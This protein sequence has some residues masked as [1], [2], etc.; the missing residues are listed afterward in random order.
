MFAL[1]QKSL[2][3]ARQHQLLDTLLDRQPARSPH[4]RATR[5]HPPQRR[6]ILFESLEPRLLL[7]ADLLPGATAGTQQPPPP[8]VTL[9]L[10]TPTATTPPQI[11]WTAPLLTGDAPLYASSLVGDFD[12]DNFN[13]P[14]APVAPAGG[15]V[16]AG[17]VQGTLDFDG[18]SDTLGITLDGNQSFSLR[19]QPP[20]GVQARMEAFGTDGLSLGFVEAANAGDTLVLQM[21]SAAATGAY[22][23]LVESLAGAGSYTVEIFLNAA[24]EDPDSDDAST[25]QDLDPV[26]S[27]LLDSPGERASVIGNLAGMLPERI[28]AEENFNNTEAFQ[29]DLL[30]GVWELTTTSLDASIGQVTESGELGTASYLRMTDDQNPDTE[31][32]LVDNGD[33]GTFEATQYT[34]EST[35]TTA[36]WR[37]NLAGVTAALLEFDFGGYDA[38]GNYADLSGFGGYANFDGVSLSVGGDQWV[39]LESYGYTSG[40]NHASIN[41][42]QAAANAGLTLGT[43][44][45]IRFQMY[46]PGG[47]QIGSRDAYYRNFDNIRITTDQQEVL[48]TPAEVVSSG[49]EIANFYNPL[50]LLTDGNVP[51]LGSFFADGTNVYWYD[52]EASEVGVSPSELSPAA[53]ELSGLV[54]GLEF[55]SVQR[56]TGLLL[57]LD[58]NDY[59]SVDYSLDGLS[60][61]RLVDI[62]AWQGQVD[63]G[64]DTFRISSP[65]PDNVDAPSFSPVQA[66][67]LRLYATAGDGA[68]AIGEVQAFT[69]GSSD[70]ADYY[71]LTLVEGEIVSFTLA[72]ENPADDN[73]VLLQLFDADGN[74]LT[75]GLPGMG[76][77][78]VTIENFLAP[79]AGSYTVRVAGNTTGDYHLAAVKNAQFGPARTGLQDLTLTPVLL[80]GLSVGGSTIRVGVLG[81]GYLVDQLNDDTHFDFSASYVDYYQ[82]DSALEL[83]SFDVIVM[84]NYI[85]PYDLGGIAPTLRTWVE[86]GHGLVT[87]GWMNYYASLRY[88]DSVNA[89]LDAIIPINLN[90]YSNYQYGRPTVTVTDSTHPVTLGLTDFTANVDAYYVYGENGIDAD[91]VLLG[92]AFGA[93]AI[94]AGTPQAGRTVAL[95]P[96]YSDFESFSVGQPARLLEQAVAWAAKPANLYTVQAQAGAV[97]TITLDLLGSGLGEPVNDLAPV[98]EIFDA[99]GSMLLTSGTTLASVDV[100]EDALYTVR[101]TGVGTGDFLLRASG[102]LPSGATPVEVIASNLDGLSQ[103]QDFPNQIDLTFSEPVLYT[104]LAAEDLMVNGVAAIGYSILSPTQVRFNMAD[105][106]TGDGVYTLVLSEGSVTDIHGNASA[107]WVHTLTVDTQALTVVASSVAEGDILEPGAQT[108]SFVLS[109]ALDDTYLGSGDLW[110]R[111]VLTNQYISVS[112]FSYDSS[113]L[114]VSATTPSL[115]EGLYEVTLNSDFFAFKDLVGNLL[116]GNG[117]GTGGDP[118]RLRFA[119]DRAASGAPVLNAVMPLGGLVY[120]ADVTDRALHAVGDTDAFTFTLAAGQTL[121]LMANQTTGSA[122]MALELFDAATGGN[123]LGLVQAST[124]GQTVLLQTLAITGGTYRAEVRSLEGAARYTLSA[125]LNAALEAELAPGSSNDTQATAQDISNS[126]LVTG[127]DRAAV[128]GQNSSGQQDWY[129][130]HLDANQIASFVLT[131]ATS[132]GAS[133]LGLELY[134]AAGV[135][136]TAGGDTAANVDES[137]IDFRALEAGDYFLRVTGNSAGWYNLVATRDQS[138]SL[139]LRDALQDISATGEVLGGLGSGSG[140]GGNGL[141][142]VVAAPGNNTGLQ[143]IVAQLND[144]TFANNNAVFVSVSDVDTLQELSQFSAVLIGG[145]GHYSNQFSGFA[146]NLRAYVEGGGGL[147]VTGWGIY[148]AGGLFGQTDA[149]FNAIVPVNTASYSWFGYPTINPISGHP[150]TNGVTSFGGSEYTEY[151]SSSPQIKTGATVLATVGGTPVA[152]AMDVGKGRSVYLGPTYAGSTTYNTAT[153]RTGEAD[154]LLEQAAAWVAG[155]TEDRYR[156]TV[157][158]GDTLTLRTTTPLDGAG[159]PGNALDVGIELRDASGA[160]VA[161]VSGGA[162]DGRNVEFVHVALDSG[163]YTVRVFSDNASPQGAYVLSVSGATGTDS[164]APVVIQSN[165]MDG[166]RLTSVPTTLSFDLSHTVLTSSLSV[167][168]L[169]ID[170]G[171]TVTGVEMVDGDTVRFTLSVPDAEGTYQ[172]SLLAGALTGLQGGLSQAHAGSFTVDKTAPRIVSQAPEVQS[173]SP[174]NTW[175]VTFNEALNPATVQTGDFVLR[176][177]N[178]NSVFINTAVVSEDRLTVTL[179]FSNQFTQGNYQLTVGPN[180][181]DAAGNLMDQDSATEGNQTYLGTVQVASP[182]LNPI[183][184]SVTL[185]D[186]S[187]V[188]EGGAA[189]G[190]QV[191]V[192]WTVRNIGTDAARSSGWYDR[193]FISSDTNPSGDIQLSEHLVSNPSGL[194]A[195]GQYAM[196]A[197]VTLPL[198]D[199]MGAGQYY[200][201]VQTDN[202]G[203]QPENNENNNA[204]YSAAFATLVPPLPDLT[205]SNVVAPAVIEAAKVIT[206]SWTVN[207]QGGATASGSSGSWWDRVVLSSDQVF[208]NGDDVY[209]NDI[210]FFSTVA[211]GQSENRST[212]VTVP[213][214]RTGTWHVLVKADFY[215]NVYERDNEN[216]NAGATSAPV[217]VIIPTEDLTPVSLTAPAAAVFGN[218]IEVSWTVRNAGTGPTYGNWYDRLYLS[219]DAVLGSGD[220]ALN[221]VYASESPDVRPVGAGQEYTRSLQNVQLPLNVSLTDGNYFLLLRTDDGNQEPELSETNNV[222]ARAISLS[223]P[224]YPDLTVTNVEVPPSVQ[225]GQPFD[226]RFTLNNAGE[227]AATNFNN[228]IYLSSDGISLDRFVGSVF[229]D[230]SLAAGTSTTVD[231]TI[232]V[233]LYEPGTWRVIVLADSSGQ[234]YEHAS[235]GNNRGVSAT[236]VVATLPPLPDLVVSNI[237]APLQG[238]AGDTI[239][240]SWTIT[241]QGTADFSGT[242]VDRV[243]LIGGGGGTEQS[244]G[245]FSFEGSLAVGASVTRTQ[246]LTLSATQDGT[247]RFVVQTDSA[248]Q[249]NET[250]AGQ[251]NNTTQDNTDLSITFPPL[252]NLQV[253][254]I[255]PPDEPFSG[256]QTTIRWVVTNNGTGAT[257]AGSWRDQVILSLD[258]KWETLD[259]NIHLAT[260]DNPNYLPVGESYQNS[261]TISIPRGLNGSYHFLVRTDVFGNVFEDAFENDNT[262][263]TDAILVQLTPPPDLRVDT[264][265][266][267]NE[268]FSGT[269]ITISWTVSNHGEGPTAEP[270]WY[271]RVIMSEN[272]ILGDADDRRLGDVLHVGRLGKS[273]PDATDDTYSVSHTFNLPIGV[274]GNFHFFVLTDVA[275]HVYEHGSDGNN[276]A[277]DMKTDGTGPELTTILLTPPPDLEVY[278]VT[279]PANVEAGH[280]YN[281]TWRVVNFGSTPTPNSS[282]TDR[283]YLSTDGVLDA[284][285]IFLRDA[286]RSGALGVVEYDDDGEFASGFYDATVSFTLP[287]NISGN[288]QLIVQTDVS[289]QVFEGFVNPTGAD[290]EDNNQTASNTMAVAN[291]PADLVVENLVVPVTGEAGKQISL[292][293][294]VRNTGTGDSVAPN[295]LD[296]VRLSVDE[297]LFD[298]DD[299]FL[300]NVFH[301]GVLN[302]GGSYTHTE[303]V[304][305]P[306]SL[307]GGTYRLYVL[308]DINGRVTE[309]SETNNTAFA[310][311][312]VLRETPD[313]QV[314]NITHEAS[315]MVGLNLDVAWRVDNLG[316]NQTNAGNW[317]DEVFLS[318]DEVLDTDDTFLGLRYRNAALASGAGYNAAASFELPATLA[319]NN[320]FVIVRTDRNNN[321]TEGAAGETNNVEVSATTVPVVAFDPN[322][323]EGVLPVAL[324]RPDLRVTAV[325]APPNA[326]SGQMMSVTWTVTN[327]STD[328]TGNRRWS[329]DVYLSRD[330][331][332]DR[333]TDLYLGYADYANL[334]A[335]ASYTQVLNVQVPYGQSGPFYLFVAT[336]SGQRITEANEL[337]N[338]AQDLAFTEV[339]LAPPADLVVGTITIPANGIPGQAATIQFSVKNEGTNPAL[340]SWTDSVYLST[341]GTWDIDDALFGVVTHHG[342]VAGGTS[343]TSSLTGILPG[344]TPGS[345]QVIV[346]SDI[347]NFIP[348][349]NENNNIK[350]TLDSVAL[351]VEALAF[352][353]AGVATDTGTLGMGQAVYYKFVVAAGETVRLSFDGAGDGLNANELYVRQGSM[354][355]RGQYDFAAREGF[356]TDPSLT[357]P[358]TEAGTYYVLAY[359]Q[360]VSG[361][362]PYTIRAEIIPFSI[363]EVNANAVGNAGDV[364]LRIEGAKFGANTEFSLVAPDGSVVT[365]HAVYLDNSSEA[366]A[367][368]SLFGAAVGSYDVRAEQ[369]VIQ[370]DGSRLVQETTIRLDA[371]TV[372][373]GLE[374]AVYMTIAG[375]TDVMVNRTAI[376]TLNYT[377]EGGADSDVPLMVVESFSATP[378]GLTAS[379]LHTTPL[380]IL[381]ASFDGPMDTLRPGARY[382]VPIVFKTGADAGALDIRVGRIL[383]TD[384]R[385]ITDWSAI[386]AGARPTDAD[387]AEWRTFWDRV[388]PLIGLTWGEYVQVLDRMMMLVS[389]PGNPVRDVREIF[390]RMMQLNPAYIPYNS[391]SGEV[392]DS[393]TDAGLADVQM[394]AYLLRADGSLEYKASALSAADGSF[395]FTRLEP[396]QYSVVAIGQALDMDR[397][398]QLDLTVPSVTLGHAAPGDAGVIYIQPPAGTGSS[399]DSN[400]SLNR[401]ANGVTHMVW[402]REGM[403]WHAWFDAASGKWKD[404]QALSSEDGYGPVITSSD[405]LFDGTTAGTIVAWQQG[406][407]NDANI[408]YAVARAKTGGGFEWSAPRQLTDVDPA[409]DPADDVLDGA[410]QIIVGDT[411]TVMFTFIKRDTGINADGTGVQDDSDLYFEIWAFGEDEFTWPSPAAV[412]AAVEDTASD[413][414]LDTEGVSAAYGRQWKFGPWNVLGGA[415]ELV[416][417]LNGT[418]SENNCKVT[419][420][421]QGQ[422]QGS[423]KG[424][425]IRSTVSGNGAVTAEWGVNQAAKDWMFNSAKASIGANVQFDWRYGLSTLLSKIPH[426]AVTAA[427]LMYSLAVGL[428]S[429]LGLEFE[430]GITFG[431]GINISVMEWKLIQPFPEFVRPDGIFEADLSG[432]FGVYAQLDVGPTGDSVRVQGDITV[433]L[434]IEPVFKIKSVTGNITFSGNIGWVPFNSVFSVTLYNN[435]STD[436]ISSDAQT[437]DVYLPIFDADALIGTG[438]AY[439]DNHVLDD[440]SQDVTSDS[441]MT[442]AKDDGVI[443]GAWTHMAETRPDEAGWLG[444]I[445]WQVMVAEY[446]AGWGT[447]V[448]LP[449]SLGVN[450]EA[451]AAV[452]GNGRRMVIWTHAASPASATP[453]QAELETAMDANNLVYALYDE[454]TGTWGAMQT[455]ATTA[456]MDNGITTTRNAAGQLVVSWV[457]QAAGGIDRL[458]TATWNGSSWSTASEVAFGASI[459]DPA[460]ERLGNDLIVVWEADANPDP[461]ETEKSLYYSIYNGASWSAGAMFDPIAMATGMALSAGLPQATTADEDL[462]LMSGFPPFPVP[463]ECLKCKPEEIKRIR[464]SAP[465]CIDG[466]GTQVTFDEKTC[467]EK[468]IVYR[469][470]V[471]RPR[472][473]NDIIGPEG[474][475]EEGWIAS[476]S[477]LDYMIRF[478]NAADASAPAQKVIITQ[479]LDDDLDWRTFRIDDFGFG[480]QIINLDGRS[481]F[482]Q[483]RLDYTADPTRGYFLD[484]S[485]SVDVTT[486]IVTWTMTTIDPATGDL[487]QEASIGFLPVNDT[488]YDP[489]DHDVV[490]VQGTGRGEGYVTY[491]VRAKSASPTG[492][493]VDAEARIIFDTEAP[494][495]TPAIAHTLD[496]GVPTSQVISF[497]NSTTTDGE[498]LVQW[499]GED[500]AAGSGLRDFSVYVSIDGGDFE[501]WLPDTTLTEAIYLGSEGHTYRFFSTVRDWAGNEERESFVADATITVTG[502]TGNISGTK[503]EDYDGDGVRDAGE[504]GLAGWTIYLDADNDSQ[505]DD[506]EIRTVTGSDGG[507]SFLDLNP[508]A[509]TV[510]EVARDGWVQ[511][512]PGASGHTANVVSGETRGGVDFGNFALAQI[513]GLLFSDRNA[514]GALDD[515]EEGLAGWTLTLDKDGNGSVEATTTT[516]EYGY[517]RFTGVGPGSYTVMQVAQA[518]WLPTGPAS[519]K[520]VAQTTSGADIGGAD[521]A[522]VQ[523]ASISGT[524]FEDENGNGQRDLDERGL[525]GWTIFLDANANG[526]LDGSERFVVTGADGAY[527]FANLLPGNYVIAEVMQDGWVQTSPGARPT[528]ATAGV[529]LSL[530]GMDVVLSLPEDVV[531]EGDISVQATSANELAATLVGLDA[532]RADPRFAGFNGSGVTT[533]VIDTGIDLNHSWFGPDADNNGVADRIVYSYDFADGDANAGDLNGH[534][535]HI[536]S[537][538]GGQD[539]TYGGV[540]QGADLIALKVFKDN[541]SGLFSYLESALQWVVV[542]AGAYDVGV[543]NLSLGDG[544]NWDT[545]IGRYGLGDE[546]AALAGMNILVTAASGNNY[547]QYSGE[548]GVAYPAADPAVLAVGA[549]WSGSFGGPVNYAN[550]AIDYSTG[551]DVLAAFGQRDDALLDILAPGTRMVGANFNGGTRTMFGTSQASAYM[552]GIA[553]LAQDIALDH[554]GRKLGLAEFSSLLASTSVLVTDGDDENDNVANTGLQFARIDLLALA[555]GILALDG[556]GDTGGGGGTSTAGETRP[557]AAPGVHQFNLEAGENHTGTDFGN[558]LLGSISGTV[559]DD[560]N[561]NAG[562]DGAETGLGGWT[563]FLDGNA[564]G[565]RDIGEHATVTLADGS[566][567]FNGIGPG[568]YHVTLTGQDGWTATTPV[569]V[570]FPMASGLQADADFGVNALPTL[571]AIGGMQVHEGSVLA[572]SASAS[573]STGDSLAYSL[574]GDS[575]GATI[576]A[577]TGAFS[578][579]APDGNANAGFTVR[580]TDAAGGIAERSFTVTVANVAPSLTLGGAASVT[581]DQDFV[582]DLASSDPGQDTLSG[583]TIQWGDGSSSQ[584][585][586][587]AGSLAH[588]YAA[589]GDYTVLATASDEDGSYS[590]STTVTVLPGTLKVA[591]LTPTATGFQVRFNRGFAPDEI[592]LYDSSFYNRGA[593]DIALRDATGRSVAGSVVLDDDH[594]GLTFVRTGGLLANG[595]YTVTLDS[596]ADAFAT[597]QG[598]LLDG[599]R[600][601]IAGGHFSGSFSITGSGAVLRIGEFT[602]GAG[603][604]VD[605]PATGAGVPITISGATGAQQVSF[606]LAYDSALLQITGVTGGG[607]LPA[608]STVNADFSTPGA[609]HITLN[610]GSPLGANSLELVRLSA[611]VPGSAPY[612]AKQVLDLRDI[613]LDTGAPVRDDDGLHLAAYVGDTSGNAK[614]ST[615]DVQRIQR[616]VLRM[617]SGFGAYPLIDPVVV[618]DIN[619]NG[620]LSSLDAQ[621]VLSEVMGLDRAEIPAIPQGMTLTFSGP[622]PVV[623]AASVAAM[624]GETVVV[625]I[626]LDTAAGLESVEITLLY[627]ADSLELLDVRL[628]GLTQDFSYFVKDTSVPGRIAIDMARMSAMSGGAGTLVELEFRVAD[629]AQGS[630]AIDLQATA[631]NETRLTLNAESQPGLDPT[632][633]RIILPVAQAP[634]VVVATAEALVPESPAPSAAPVTALP[635]FEIASPV[636]QPLP[637]INFG[638]P[639]SAFGADSLS[640]AGWVGDW[641]AGNRDAT[642][643]PLKMNNWKLGAPVTRISSR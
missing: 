104:S 420:G 344:L 575:H 75:E 327:D 86:A 622:D 643:N 120:R 329:D 101:V 365:A 468:T 520:H 261:A 437:Q 512:T 97:L 370:G 552:A 500:D 111:E 625:P 618:A 179:S 63:F 466:G 271:D 328:P 178:N 597:A 51:A 603:Q 425:N 194:V 54:F 278:S 610:L 192:N 350:G 60:W 173:I 310:T 317:Y 640:P 233:P 5:L 39:V 473:P 536:A 143:S 43:D 364:T 214:N 620:A 526:S 87:T 204:L 549:V 164:P 304:T 426:P 568:Q 275:N 499:G 156:I 451:T 145:V 11:H 638:Q 113:T 602:R 372:S 174:F 609:V 413:P 554:L 507:Y 527:H 266:A 409:R 517:Y 467:T 211:A 123:S 599:N 530:S 494:I 326:I 152:A 393:E 31:T 635:S 570:S 93:P 257:S 335:G 283:L 492:T 566:Y 408:W 551:A 91:A 515:G 129:T 325:D 577:T 141:I 285:D 555:E 632:D 491:T 240:F 581:D 313:L 36:T 35:L 171:A 634:V 397:D 465:N 613:A 456:G 300:E 312:Q 606:T 538:I 83:A 220:I 379:D 576:D 218:S 395:N 256:T 61:S 49:Q 346:R 522:N 188:P 90:T 510:R 122:R 332:F 241:N 134:D 53:G 65:S 585:D 392:R 22:S 503:F 390:S 294:T 176:D 18:D 291:R 483:A 421:A 524:K 593:A 443:F 355:S 342:D 262:R 472:D 378:M 219:T 319:P 318:L 627:P 73:G 450:S 400:P 66:R 429:K 561:A 52:Q 391:L 165:P 386:E 50:D 177:P 478:E 167:D 27:A 158:A 384:T 316:T 68:Y 137:I 231:K 34:Y 446:G 535:S 431:G 435:E 213:T 169:G 128:L 339:A 337:N 374:A 58:N 375:P 442:L 82:I 324:L 574:T 589:P 309:S 474:Y 455:L 371:I 579:T 637:Q 84:G 64:M 550:G 20:A 596:R 445:G 564:N 557:L 369:I 162:A 70:L 150:I 511:T 133:D 17:G 359:G 116:D 614:Y 118:Y 242:W 513:G 567:R 6:K 287:F 198:N 108:L 250:P 195:G 418:V 509:Y 180:I 79:A 15:L 459:M 290:G 495:D 354:P 14:L 403:V 405:K 274:V 121:S 106:L 415:A 560:R 272:D 428:G 471:V 202:Y 78:A 321:V 13:S 320:Y 124:L 2:E 479:Q 373:E 430:D 469:P 565:Q 388:Q 440:V 605:V 448:A 496:A 608:G 110:L 273:D 623:S 8:Q 569:A 206:V 149:D 419:L 85:D 621:R 612:G 42:V 533:V 270:S 234:V 189:L 360:A 114:T 23:I 458:M 629:D 519:G 537:L 486:G 323:P 248:N 25:A 452:D 253:T 221:Y 197:L 187:P 115:A 224:D 45:R 414:A 532:F 438:F 94:V 439:G 298:D 592:N 407:G 157:Q 349:S 280:V 504:T 74:L 636:V 193:L 460:M 1:I 153:L 3:R 584:L 505:L 558:F 353:S 394:A 279:V 389:E 40:W 544:E 146:A 476:R 196:S 470:C 580:V 282:W 617:D 95:S 412:V 630:L 382:S 99:T 311:I 135:L 529:T 367:T 547:F 244:F 148:A 619:G 163:N 92:S 140:G 401:D 368:F 264:V 543:V 303:T 210:R 159:A 216:N 377:N 281:A 47:T 30:D 387:D 358:T 296:Q 295:W 347:R 406:K 307:T 562:Q 268:E 607:G 132:L 44:T 201:R 251:L 255:T 21:R 362:S 548:L 351:D 172:Y 488:V 348:E 506:G 376:F 184:I 19:L 539:A 175:S 534:G 518:G 423:V 10:A 237:V 361:A 631:L 424:S 170:G 366:Y 138:F 126:L 398:G 463:E 41:L 212:T 449:G 32:V 117:D 501:I 33:G 249:V 215:N 112:G 131:P 69:D 598:G 217:Q 441:A 154:Q 641:V 573:D 642:T 475:G 315:G 582:L 333:A 308:G 127:S 591:A 410:V 396:G 447:P 411:G 432:T 207:N 183:A 191:R 611:Q 238:L 586:A 107:V 314:S 334:A 490:L 223:V 100:L 59:Y 136:L 190:S 98:L 489:N 563:V 341:D 102:N 404:A 247:R 601:G 571:A 633:G 55:A 556:P 227:A 380:Y 230:Q 572:F 477:V 209:L 516:D 604:A 330:G 200:I 639:V 331:V 385:L 208:G 615:L 37:V 16:Y 125:V 7:S 546:L 182:D 559:F 594:Q 286:G 301:T 545:A 109:E 600:D 480:D 246:N 62:A 203:N 523:A 482:Y 263:V 616:A 235:E 481:A 306:F 338:T 71:S 245:N 29:A 252:P 288:Y 299:I 259:D 236:A 24:L 119:V 356:V 508:G 168:D 453:T 497:A 222:I 80:D 269:P 487:P 433:T 161:T 160:V 147:I 528:S 199:S 9:Q 139:E 531:V 583:W 226:I 239:T 4:R 352:N 525:P 289:N 485:A 484:V 67:Y 56:V 462:S 185:P 540:A 155:D 292:T 381:A 186:G 628:G 422:I 461:E 417:A 48:L 96:A 258:D 76:S 88:F 454:S 383:T 105:P 542:N 26:F 305:L 624:P 232:T 284:G 553:T 493:V 28:L 336:D 151:P 578:W 229:V 416:L 265:E 293:W 340:G 166:Q 343:Y 38:Y 345:Y 626:T 276:S 225:S 46:D 277:L 243:Y 434:G 587:A 297:I 81:G 103:V 541:G 502:A 444:K 72:L 498:F 89:D 57:S 457:Y 357:I 205:V 228:L 514:N 588:R 427:H 267:P 399:T 302:A 12:L 77:V 142:A 521:F 436:V 322:N 260:V 363:T 254:A 144:Q 590:T 595:S 181:Q 402:T 464:E 130:L